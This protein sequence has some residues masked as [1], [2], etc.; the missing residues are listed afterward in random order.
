MYMGNRGE[1]LDVLLRLHEVDGVSTTSSTARRTRLARKT[2]G[3][4]APYSGVSMLVG[5]ASPVH[6]YA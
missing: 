4:Q 1:I 2:H 3:P 5:P 6:G